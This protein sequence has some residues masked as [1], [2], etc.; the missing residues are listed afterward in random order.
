LAVYHADYVGVSFQHSPR[1][2]CYLGQRQAHVGGQSPPVACNYG[3]GDVGLV[4]P[5]G[6]VKPGRHLAGQPADVGRRIKD[7]FSKY[8]AVAQEQAFGRGGPEV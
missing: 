4:D 3:A 7:L 1:V 2:A 8:L 5:G 6:P